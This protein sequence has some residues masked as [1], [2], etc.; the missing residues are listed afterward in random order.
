MNKF[1]SF[2]LNLFVYGVLFSSATMVVYHRYLFQ[3]IC[4]AYTTYNN[5][6]TALN[7]FKW[8]DKK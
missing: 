5:V 3:P 1:K 7:P 4:T 8:S 6:E 2:L